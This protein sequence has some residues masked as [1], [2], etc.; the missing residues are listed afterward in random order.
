MIKY[1]DLGL[2]NRSFFSEFEKTFKET[3]HSGWYILGNSVANFEQSFSTYCG[4]NYCVGLASGLD[5]LTLAVEACEFEKNS[6]IIV[7]SNTYIATIIAIIRAGMK[8]VLVEPDIRTYN[9]DPDKVE[10]KINGNTRAILVVHLYGRLCDIDK[11][12][13]IANTQNLRVIEDCAQAHGASIN[14]T[15]AGNFG[16]IGCF[17]FYPTKNLGALGDAGAITTNS[18]ELASKIKTL[19]NYGSNKKYH[20]EK[21]GLNSRLDEI[22]AAFLSIKLKSLDN[23]NKHKQKLAG[24]YETE[25]RSDFIKPIPLTDNECVFHIYNIRHEKRDKVKKH[26]LEHNILSDIHYPIPPYKQRALTNLFTENQEYPVSSEIHETTLSLPCS[27]CHTV[28]DIM[29]TIEVLN[30]F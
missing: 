16:D 6:E 13:Q 4:T 25:L 10:A 18:S 19:R 23:I 14:G 3:L 7:P 17:S 8:P 9:I 1:E 11:I 29:Q 28:E 26:L 21:I 15:K 2:T 24:I 12:N 22:Q 5:A 30:N 20:N 27:Y